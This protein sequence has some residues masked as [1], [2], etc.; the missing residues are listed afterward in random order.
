MTGGYD[1]FSQVSFINCMNLRVL[2]ASWNYL[3]KID[4]P[5]HFETE[6]P[7]QLTID[8]SVNNLIWLD[9]DFGTHAEFSLDRLFLAKNNLGPQLTNETIPNLIRTLKNLTELDLSDNSI[10]SLPSNFFVHQLKM[11]RI[12]LSQNAMRL[13]NFKFTHMKNLTLLDL[14]RNLL[15]Q[16][17]RE[18]R[19]AIVNVSNLTVDLTDNPLLCSCLT[20]DF[21][22]WLREESGHLKNWEEYDCTFGKQQVSLS[23]LDNL[24]LPKLQKECH[25][26]EWVI[27]SSVVL[28]GVILLLVVSFV[29][30]RH[31]FEIR[32]LCLRL[33][34]KRREHQALEERDVVYDYDAFV[35]FDQQDRNWIDDHL[36]PRLDC[37]DGEGKYRLLVHHRDFLP[38]TNIEE[39]ILNGI[40]SSRKII[41]IS[42]STLCE[43]QLVPV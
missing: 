39:N 31:R 35:A 25:S 41:L 23:K 14:S 11:E 37:Q 30:Y 38:G 6:A 36:I 17:D 3:E 21:L 22:E 26:K 42:D 7:K 16:L 15:D 40:Q 34:I 27:A 33:V 43:E 1:S 18:T 4:G 9:P 32:Y 8:F 12:D 24:I 13:I 28:V 2:N 19:M 10:K 20:L 29:F 5:L